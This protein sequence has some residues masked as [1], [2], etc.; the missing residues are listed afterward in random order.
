MIIEPLW[1]GVRDY[2]RAFDLTAIEVRRDGRI[3]R[4]RNPAG[5]DVAWWCEA[6]DVGRLMRAAKDGD[7]PSAAAALGITITEHATVVERAKGAV[8]RIE[9]R[10][11][12]AQRTGALAAFNS[13][14]RR[15]RLEAAR[16][17]RRFMTYR[18]AR[19]RL[20]KALGKVAA[21]EP[22]AIVREVF[23]SPLTDPDSGR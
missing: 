11:A 23:G 5:A 2:L 1:P 22:V 10:V 7:V 12:Q 4:T 3:I 8:A 19:A 17:G 15:R 6:R 21:G 9:E 14:Y 13:E 18:Q 16:D 20:R